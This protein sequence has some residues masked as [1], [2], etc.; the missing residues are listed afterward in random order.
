MPLLPW[1]LL[2]GVCV[3]G[4]ACAQDPRAPLDTADAA[5][6]RGAGSSDAAA[7]AEQDAAP[8]PS[9][10]VSG[11]R[12]EPGRPASYYGPKCTAA[13]SF[14]LLPECISAV[15]TER[16]GLV[17]LFLNFCVVNGV[18]RCA[19]RQAPSPLYLSLLLPMTAWSEGHYTHAVAGLVDLQL[20]DGRHHRVDT[21][22]GEPL[23]LDLVIRRQPNGPDATTLYGELE[24][25]IPRVDAPGP[26]FTLR[27]RVN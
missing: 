5:V 6:A 11:G 10:L 21:G 25:D 7:G 3:V 1:Q 14:A 22:R 19:E 24:L 9:D 27:A 2:A 23:P 18:D 26:P 15:I 13:V 20:S 16:E 17:H 8:A 4:A 12:P